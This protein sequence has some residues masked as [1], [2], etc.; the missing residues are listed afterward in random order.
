MQWRFVR[1]AIEWYI[2]V[3]SHRKVTTNLIYHGTTEKYTM[4]IVELQKILSAFP[5]TYPTSLLSITI[6][7]IAC[8]DTKT[9][10]YIFGIASYIGST[11]ENTI[12]LLT[13]FF[14][15]ILSALQFKLVKTYK[16]HTAILISSTIICSLSVQLYYPTVFICSL[17]LA[18]I[19]SIS[20]FAHIF[21]AQPDF[22]RKKIRTLKLISEYASFASILSAFLTLVK[23][24]AEVTK[25][26]SFPIESHLLIIVTA[27]LMVFI[28]TM[29]KIA[30]AIEELEAEKLK[31]LIKKRNDYIALMNKDEIKSSMGIYNSAKIV[32]LD[33]DLIKKV[34]ALDDSHRKATIQNITSYLESIRMIIS[35]S[36]ATR[37]YSEFLAKKNN[38]EKTNGEKSNDDEPTNYYQALIATTN[39]ADL[40]MPFREG[41]KEMYQLVDKPQKKFKLMQSE[42]SK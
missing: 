5:L 1:T 40:E 35:N 2:L 34:K 19:T 27:I 38:A 31:E 25:N 37:N 4:K 12:L 32:Q 36:H 8:Q 14:I 41:L 13:A 17:P 24:M 23:T 11:T 28:A 42:D 7:N 33:A 10:T 9:Y 22:P 3:D 26:H 16:K 39:T 18:I 21:Q 20:L 15:L 29:L 6:L 30:I